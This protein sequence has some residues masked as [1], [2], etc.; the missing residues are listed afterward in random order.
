MVIFCFCL[1]KQSTWHGFKCRHK[2]MQPMPIA[3]L[4]FLF[5]IF[6]FSSPPPPSIFH[7]LFY[8]CTYMECLG[9]ST[10]HQAYRIKFDIE[11]EWRYAKHVCHMFTT[12]VLIPSTMQKCRN[13]YPLKHS[14]LFLLITTCCHCF[15]L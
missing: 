9:K 7:S 11:L 8:F 12:A 15:R 2:T 13:I 5:I 1:G 10:A 4:S 3:P 14:P 6:L